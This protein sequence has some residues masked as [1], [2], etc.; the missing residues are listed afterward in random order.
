M[1]QS[2]LKTET[3]RKIKAF[4]A[5]G[6]S[7]SEIARAFGVSRQSVS[8]IANG[9]THAKTVRWPPNRLGSLESEGAR[10]RPS[11]VERLAPKW[12]GLV[13][14][15]LHL[16]SRRAASERPNSPPAAVDMAVV[17]PEPAKDAAAGPERSNSPPAAVDVAVVAP[18]PAE[19]AAAGPERPAASVNGPAVEDVR[20]EIVFDPALEAREALERARAR[21]RAAQSREDLDAAGSEISRAAA[22]LRALENPAD[23]SPT[24]P[25]GGSP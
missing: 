10:V 24:Q 20:R 7:A 15:N 14:K 19:D 23:T 6:Y 4:L 9:K 13:G 12:Q 8:K 2:K 11:D 16:E 1:I 25:Q 21:F 18:E 5:L 17:A 3:A 22:E